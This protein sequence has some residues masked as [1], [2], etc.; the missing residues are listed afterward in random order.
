MKQE[1]IGNYLSELTNDKITQY[2]PW[3]AINYE[4]EHYD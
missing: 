1:S 3:K 4:E 2:L